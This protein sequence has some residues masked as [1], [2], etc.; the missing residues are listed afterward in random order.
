MRVTQARHESDQSARDTILYDL[1]RI[2]FVHA[3]A[4]TGKTAALVGRIVGLITSGR[5]EI[6]EIAAITF[7]EAAASELK[8][9]LS[10][11]LERA[12]RQLDDV[13]ADGEEKEQLSRGSS[14]PSSFDSSETLARPDPYPGHDRTDSIKL[15]WRALKDI[16]LA[17][18][19]TFHGF[20]RKLLQE[21][22]F[23]A[24]LPP[25]FDVSD[26]VT[27]GVKFDGLWNAFIDAL[28]RDENYRDALSQANALGMKIDGL[29]TVAQRIYE[30]W[31]PSATYATTV[32]HPHSL[33]QIDFSPVITG[34][35]EAVG[36]SASCTDP[37]DKMLAHLDRLKE[38]A[39]YLRSCTDPY[40]RL[41]YLANA[42]KASSNLGKKGSWSG[43]KE[44]LTTLLEE[45]DE[46]LESLLSRARDDALVKLLSAVFK[47]AADS[48][49]SRV[50][51][52]DL[53]YN[54]LLVLTRN[55]LRNNSRV[56][57]GSSEK[58]RYLLIDEFQDTDPIQV[59]IV[60]LI[61]APD[62]QRLT[63]IRVG[64]A[65]F[66]QTEIEAGRV[67]F[68]GDP[69][70]S[71]YRFRR[72]DFEMYTRT[73]DHFSSSVVSLSRNYRSVSGVLDWINSVFG[74]LFGDGIERFQPSYESLH[75]HRVTSAT[76]TS[77][78]VVLLGGPAAP[79]TSVESVREAEAKDVVA[80][81]ERLMSERWP[82]GD[83]GRPARLVDI[84]ILIPNRRSLPALVRAMDDKNVPYRIESS[85]LVY[86]TTEIRELMLIVASICDPTDEI[87]LLGALRSAI[88]GCGDD[89]LVEYS[90][91]GGSW[92]YRDPIPGSLSMDHPVVEC[93]RILRELNELHTWL[94]VA[95]L[96]DRILSSRRVFI[97]ALGGSRHRDVWRRFRFVLEQA[98]VFETTYG[99]DL[100]RYLRWVREQEI[101]RSKA[102]EIILPENDH[103]A[104]RIMTI[105]AAKGLEF[106]VVVVSGTGSIESR[107]TGPSVLF[108]SNGP[109]V[110][111]SKNLYTSG[112]ADLRETESVIDEC[113]KTRLL[114]VA[115]TRARDHLIVSTHRTS[116]G[117]HSQVSRLEEICDGCPELW[118]R[119]EDDS[120]GQL[121]E[122]A[123]RLV[124]K[125]LRG[126]RGVDDDR[127]MDRE[128]VEN[129]DERIP[130]SPAAS[131]SEIRERWIQ[132]RRSR[133]ESS[134]RGHVISATSLASLARASTGDSLGQG[135]ELPVASERIL[136]DDLASTASRWG[137]DGGDALSRW[138]QRTRGRAGTA[139]GR[140]VHAV[141][142]CVDLRSGEG[143]K[144]LARG[145]ALSE[146]VPAQESEIKRLAAMA[147]S[148]KIVKEAV[149]RGS[150]WRE[151][152]VGVPIGDV[153]LEG[154][155]DLLFEGPDGLEIVDYKTDRAGG[156]EEL[157]EVSGRYRLQ[158]A[159][160][161]VAIEECLKRSVSRCTFLF[162]RDDGSI[163]REIEDL[164]GAK[165]EVRAVLSNV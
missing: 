105:H 84:A 158:G 26:A 153:L 135:R 59:D 46:K 116:T 24:G 34:L 69:K 74:E 147:L 56:R 88:L 126:I 22:S 79:K 144:D 114:Y 159:A 86:S 91:K 165:D 102:E 136:G 32:S 95:S 163:E 83:D 76:H 113:E 120:D 7:T 50:S 93:Q 150:Y 106:P 12:A 20:A 77:P 111:L 155:I 52:A 68:V 30:T 73:H 38:R 104:V 87:S 31:D 81:I 61:A 141:L 101:E 66:P 132:E 49:S 107:R 140:A 8:D 94:S 41:E 10:E 63:D 142:Q 80:S 53:T 108:G 143:L 43:K 133:L 25:S 75:A 58:Y 128:L 44:S 134:L 131:S 121:H 55:L 100:P 122:D 164:F 99:N 21:N 139:V 11:E 110:Y 119:M 70:Q 82:V 157:S 72:A 103:E 35:D 47:F 96:L 16:D 92:D 60:M 156:D 118:R 161:A 62:A 5:A 23:E 54:D 39:E 6:T 117:S 90:T 33:A 17:S 9:R 148:S 71:I 18:I 65:E 51:E 138:R 130:V 2:A 19:S 129:R 67:F 89:D 27:S 137:Q 115:A 160:Y 1:D 57:R 3:G 112:F 162:L 48:F 124:T 98:R 145:F 151:M 85:S 146:K 154:I 152:Y 97:Q 4:G 15:L 45:I 109:E 37:D 123:E 42:K 78:P 64:N 125:E 28:L 13:D 149:S 29:R 36:F 127:E 40:E 14:G